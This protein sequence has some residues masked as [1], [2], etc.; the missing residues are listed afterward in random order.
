M[1]NAL[2]SFMLAAGVSA[3]VYQKFQK[4]SGNNTQQS[5]IATAITGLIVF[6]VSIVVLGIIL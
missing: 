4:Y 6:I 5:A 3:W 1:S 2:I